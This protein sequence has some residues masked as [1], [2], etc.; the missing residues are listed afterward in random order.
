MYWEREYSKRRFSEIDSNMPWILRRI[1][2]HFSYARGMYFLAALMLVL[3]WAL[4]S[5]G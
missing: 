2:H 3:M 4:G 5:F 1:G